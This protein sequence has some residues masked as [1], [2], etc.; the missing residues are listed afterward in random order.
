MLHCCPETQKI[1]GTNIRDK[2]GERCM[3]KREEFTFDSR[4]GQSKISAYRWIPEEHEMTDNAPFC[5]VQIIHGM[6]EYALRYEE[7]ATYL[8][9]RGIIVVAD[10][11]LGHGR[12]VTKGNPYGYMCEQDPAT[13]MVRDEHRLKKL[14]Q[15]KY[16]GVPYLII[17][18]SMGS[19][20]LRNYLTRYGT[21]IDGAVIM[22]TGFESIAKMNF[23]L[24]LARIISAVK[25]SK[26]PS[27]LLQKI[28]FSVYL[29]RIENPRTKFDWLTRD[30]KIVDAFAADSRCNFIFTVNG[31]STL[32]ELVKRA[33][34]VKK[35]GEIPKKLP[36]LIVSGAEDPVGS[37]GVGPKK[38]Y[39]LYLN[40]DLT[41]TQLKLYNGS[42]HEILNEID[43]EIVYID[44]YNWICNVVDCMA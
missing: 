39:D 11:H 14:T 15:E 30:E 34:N 38:L 1:L 10:D 16:P 13:V 31:F 32:M 35:M 37:W 33:Q 20:I 21:G 36:L 27:K 2:K 19:Y 44:L 12:S 23:G 5:I 40:L 24:F 9:E 8:A 43:R 28:G 18:H 3:A 29:K 26:Y 6:Q 7:F 42:R 25:G 22:G 41:K 4:D 17:G